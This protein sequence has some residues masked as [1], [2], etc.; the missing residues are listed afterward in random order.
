MR[1]VVLHLGHERTAASRESVRANQE[2]PDPHVHTD[3]LCGLFGRHV[4]GHA[5]LQEEPGLSQDQA[6]GFDGQ[7]QNLALILA[8]G[9]PRL[10]PAFDGGNGNGEV[11]V[12]EQREKPVV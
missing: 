1:F 8:N 9:K 5:D 2:L 12:P 6:G 3:R 11:S 10:D 7:L 4:V